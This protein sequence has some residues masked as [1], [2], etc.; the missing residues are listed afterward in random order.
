MCYITPAL[1]ARFFF[2]S[3]STDLD[4]LYSCEK[5]A[6]YYLEPEDRDVWGVCVSVCV[7]VY[8]EN[9]QF[10]TERITV[11]KSVPTAFSLPPFCNL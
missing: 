8:W 11:V 7:C 4:N 3:L 6:A 9:G 1:I 5:S 2:F 10:D